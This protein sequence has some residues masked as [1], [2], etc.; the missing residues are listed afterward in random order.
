MSKKVLTNI[1]A[2]VLVIFAGEMLPILSP[3]KIAALLESVSKIPLLG[4]IK[5]FSLLLLILT[6]IIVIFVICKLIVVLIKIIRSNRWDVVSS[7]VLSGVLVIFFEQARYTE[8][9]NSYKQFIDLYKES[10]LLFLPTVFVLVAVA[11]IA[12]SLN[13]HWKYLFNLFDRYVCWTSQRLEQLFFKQVKAE[14]I[15]PLSP[16]KTLSDDPWAAGKEDLLNY[17]PLAESF[18]K[19]ILEGVSDTSIVFGLEAP[20]GAGKTSFLEMCRIE[21]DKEEQ[22]PL[23]V[24]FNPWHFDTEADLVKKYFE[25]LKAVINKKYFSPELNSSISKYVSLISSVAIEWLSLKPLQKTED[26]KNTHDELS[27]LLKQLNLKIIVIV[28]DLDRIPLDKAKQI[29]KL[30]ALCAD[31]PNIRYVLCYDLENLYSADT[32]TVI[33]RTKGSIALQPENGMQGQPGYQPPNNVNLK[34]VQ[35]IDNSPLQSYLE[36]IINIKYILPYYQKERVLSYLIDTLYAAFFEFD[37]NRGYIPEIVPISK[38]KLRDD[39]IHFFDENPYIARRFVFS[40]RQVKSIVKTFLGAQKENPRFFTYDI[41]KIEH[42]ILLIILKYHFPKVYADI[43]YYEYGKDR[44]FFLDTPKYRFTARE[45]Y[46][47]T[48]PKPTYKSYVADFGLDNTVSDI[49]SILFDADRAYNS[50]REYLN[51]YQL[52]QYIKFIEG[53][54][55]G[56]LTDSVFLEFFKNF[57]KQIGTDILSKFTSYITRVVPRLAGEALETMI[58]RS[59]MITEF[60]RK[61]HQ[62]VYDV[63]K[64]DDQLSDQ[65][66]NEVIEYLPRFSLYESEN[67]PGTRNNLFYLI[68]KIINDGVW[69]KKGEGHNSVENVK[70]IA[71]YLLKDGKNETVIEQMGKSRGV[72]GIYEI[73]HLRY[74]CNQSRGGDMWEV[75]RALMWHKL[76]ENGKKTVSDSEINQNNDQVSIE[77]ITQN[78]FAVF[79]EEFIDK[80]RN[81]LGEVEELTAEEILG[82]EIAENSEWLKVIKSEEQFESKIGLERA[83]IEM[84][85]IYDLCFEGN[86]TGIKSG[87]YKY[88]GKKIRDIMQD[89]LFE[90]CFVDAQNQERA[91]ESFVNLLLRGFENINSFS[92]RN[93]YR[94]DFKKITNILDGVKLLKYW[95]EHRDQ[96]KLI[97]KDKQGV[98]HAGGYDVFFHDNEKSLSDLSNSEKTGVFDILDKEIIALSAP[99]AA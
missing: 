11:I 46:D 30:V 74:S 72:I 16:L 8:T 95:E 85:S 70:I 92:E 63:N 79:K 6:A 17:A 37:S 45:T 23:I 42:V 98:L 66:L 64:V 28:D 1:Y 14:D 67:A 82:K 84:F 5:T 33:D 54:D 12:V 10:I 41:A 91:Y 73:L 52:N 75:S 18:A 96:I 94:F 90:T 59:F 83:K 9:F 21:W 7:V 56:N 29:L 69:N 19:R 57:S 47:H 34:T 71:Q 97:Y 27:L 93:K 65:M 15:Q 26:I 36:K 25:Q 58:K 31:F 40:L 20:W 88:E 77:E 35:Q 2:S 22:R 51:T 48:P 68:L 49:L 32:Y 87:G 89:Y 38:Q 60:Y 80:E 43:C 13:I 99:A 76:T 61:F 81:F 55:D 24:N 39:L 78:V 86:Y 62:K 53:V 4:E 3:I 44:G 50:N